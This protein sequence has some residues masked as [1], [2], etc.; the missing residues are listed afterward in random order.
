M[1]AG[2]RSVVV[3]HGQA[4]ELVLVLDV[5]VLTLPVHLTEEVRESNPARAMACLTARE[6]RSARS[7]ASI[8]H[9]SRDTRKKQV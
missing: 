7:C 5:R 8:Q 6:R 4:R 9:P 1:V 2:L 3:R